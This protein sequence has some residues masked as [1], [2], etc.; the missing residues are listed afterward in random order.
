MYGLFHTAFGPSYMY[1]ESVFEWHK[2]HKEGSESVKDDERCG[3][4][5]EIRI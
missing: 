1:R 3:M 5:N 2:R 4:S